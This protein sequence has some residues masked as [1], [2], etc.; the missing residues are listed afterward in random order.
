MI[1]TKEP[2][3]IVHVMKNYEEKRGGIYNVVHNL[4]SHS[5]PNIRQYVMTNKSS[6]AASE[7]YVLHTQEQLNAIKPQIIHLHGMSTRKKEIYE[8]VQVEGYKSDLT[9][10]R[11]YYSRGISFFLKKAYQLIFVLKMVKACVISFNP[12]LRGTS[13]SEIVL[14]WKMLKI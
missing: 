9:F 2:L 10:F 7:S 12:S 5:A 13:K 14:R 4:L 1:D 3:I 6:V 8:K 11:K